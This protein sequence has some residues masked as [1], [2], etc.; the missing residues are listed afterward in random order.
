M[1]S[2]FVNV[3]VVLARVEATIFLLDE[4]EGRCLWGVGGVDLASF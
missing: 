4:E 3:A 1:D 2:V